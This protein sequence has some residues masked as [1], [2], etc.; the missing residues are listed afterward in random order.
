MS[1]RLC[2]EAVV[3]PEKRPVSQPQNFPETK[4]RCVSR[5]SDGRENVAGLAVNCGLEMMAALS[6]FNQRLKHLLFREQIGIAAGDRVAGNH[7]RNGERE[8]WK[9]L[10]DDRRASASIFCADEAFMPLLCGVTWATMAG[11]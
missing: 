1:L 4:T 10:E 3:N 2:D 8:P 11:Q 6:E 7:R 5:V 9:S